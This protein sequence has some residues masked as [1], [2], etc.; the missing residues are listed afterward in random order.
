MSPAEPEVFVREFLS[1]F[2]ESRLVNGLISTD[3]Y[4]DHLTGLRRNGGL[5]D[6]FRQ[7]F[8]SSPDLVQLDGYGRLRV[9]HLR[10]PDGRI[11]KHVRRAS[12]AAS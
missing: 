12:C 6:L 5:S 7:L 10:E 1:S 11:S 9:I 8:E 2:L 4:H 3:Q